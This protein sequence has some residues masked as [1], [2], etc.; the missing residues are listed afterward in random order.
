M[1]VKFGC[2]KIIIIVIITFA[3]NCSTCAGWL[4]VIPREATLD[5]DLQI[6]QELP[7]AKV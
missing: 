1:I 2:N 5:R 3:S 7:L 4:K 6:G